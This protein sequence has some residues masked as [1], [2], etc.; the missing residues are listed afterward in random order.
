VSQAY[1]EVT[2][3][4]VVV[5]LVHRF[6]ENRSDYLRPGYKEFQLRQEFLDPLLA[7]LGWDMNNAD[8]YAEAYKD[9]V[10]EDTIRIGGQAKAPD[11]CFRA[12]GTRKFFVEAKKPAVRLKTDTAA[13]YQLRRY[14]WS[15]K[16]PLSILTDFDELAVYDCRVR[17]N[18]TDKASTARLLYLTADE[19]ASRWDEIAAVFSREAVLRGSFDRYAIAIT[20]RRGTAEVDAT[21]LADIEAW[22]EQLARN[23]ALRNR[24]LA[25][26]RHDL[27]YAV[28]ATIDRIVF[29]RICEDRG[30]E[31]NDLA[32]AAAGKDVYPK[33]LELFRAA[34]QRYNS[35]LFH[36]S[37][38]KGREEE[39]DRL[40][41]QLRVDD[42]VMKKIIGGLY[43]PQSPYEFSVIGADI[44]GR[45][46]EQFL[47]K[48]IQLHGSRVTV[49]D[50]PEVK[51]AGG[52]YYTPSFVVDYIV[53]ATLDPML[54]GKTPPQAEQ[55]HIVD[56]AC[57][58]GSFLVA[59]YQHLLDWHL[60][61]Y[62]AYKRAPRQIHQTPTGAWRLTTTERKRILINNIY[63]VDIDPQAVEV[64]KLSLLLKVIEG[65]TQTELA[66]GR[67]LP[68][69]ADN[70][71]CGNS[72]I[73]D[74]YYATNTLPGIT[75]DDDPVNVFNWPDAFPAVFAA[76]GFDTVIG[77]PPYLSVDDTWGKRDPRLAYLK[78]AYADV[79]NDKTDVLIYFLAKAVDISRGEVAFIV[80]RAFLEAYKADKLRG[81]LAD[82]TRVRQ[83]IDFRNAYVF[84]G[85]GITTAIVH[86]TKAP[87]ITPAR[88]TRY[89]PR[90]LPA[91]F[92]AAAIGEDGFHT[93]SVPQNRFTA[94]PWVF[95]T[96]TAQA[97][98]DQIDDA[99]EP[100]GSVLHVGQGMQTGR[101]TVFG[102][103]DQATIDAWA[104]PEK[105]YYQRVRNSDI[106]RYHFATTGRYLLYTEAFTAFSQLPA[107]AQAH[108][109]AH[110][111]EL[112][113][114]AAYQRGNCQWWQWTWPLHKQYINRN[115][116]Y[117]PYL[118]TDNRFALDTTHSLLGLTD[119]TALYDKGQPEDVRYLLGLL[120]SSLLTYR[121]RY[122]GKL[123]SGG[124]LEY[125]WNSISKLPIRRI[126]PTDPRHQRMVEL[127]QR[128][129]DSHAAAGRVR[130][131][132]DRTRI[133]SQ[134]KTT[135]RLIDQLTYDLYGLDANQTR[136][137]HEVL[138][139]AD[140]ADRRTQRQPS[141]QDGTL[142]PQLEG[143]DVPGQ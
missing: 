108:L 129:I 69:L 59:A 141:R 47:G 43:Y 96:D 107:G 93:V 110:R 99:G 36:F 57:G 17:P 95:T 83:I 37:D 48:T 100:L 9:V 25:L 134:I 63:G 23:I 50:K 2:L 88:V 85:I 94:R 39:P 26:T 41:P 62:L 87:E 53:R 127:A 105:A 27:G 103:L 1:Q 15:A 56:P 113:A 28:Q 98:L 20:G 7:S 38:E 45:V 61:R 89:E 8:G 60:Q 116:I 124:I 136:T 74:D 46:Y 51:K 102:G 81:W 126:A 139:S 30:L 19:Y 14:A 109:R 64:A 135:N 32:H 132:R 65:E 55:L 75:W 125:F 130:T 123:K 11:Y 40:T 118:A 112:E 121:F 119:T 79:Y 72:L 71:K 111:A 115:K 21:F 10:H 101:N 77:N 92:T 76:G 12:G 122:I 70:I 128:M 3:P 142:L 97:L 84:D 5:E 13:A 140:A 24:H 67:L 35:G 33:L 104:L 117:C 106:Q 91:G 42:Q 120:N 22:R 4:A 73:A 54:A 52:V 66:I 133:D 138:Q 29:L 131:P 58:S 16:L 137:I 44:L 114:R 80:S 143:D 78:T 86:L 82:H 49:E 31:G 90:H 18:P 68:D 34:D 6:T